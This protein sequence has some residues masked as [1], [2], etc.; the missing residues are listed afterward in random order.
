MRITITHNR[1]QQ[2]AIK[3]IDGAF[4]DFFKGMPFAGPL[5][6]VDQTKTWNGNKMDF[7]FTGKL[8]FFKAPITGSI[9]VEEKDLTIE[10]ELPGFLKNLLPENTV[11][12]NIETKVK[13]LLT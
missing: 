10:I 3:R 13:G 7:S 2:E 5:E 8:G 11:K 9:T 1:G 6:V 4:D 12:Q